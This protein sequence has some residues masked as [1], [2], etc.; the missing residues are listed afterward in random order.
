MRVS[1]GFHDQQADF[2]VPDD[3]LALAWKSPA[4]VESVQVAGRI[5]QA[6]REPVGCPPLDQSVVPGDQVVIALGRDVP[7]VSEV[8]RVVRAMLRSSGVETE[9]ITI[10]AEP[11]SPASL[12][13]QIPEGIVLVRHDPE[14]RTNLAYLASTT[15]G[16][17]VYLNR[18]L[19]DADFVMA[20][21]SLAY[22]PLRGQRCPSDVI[23]PG[24]SDTETRL[25]CRVSAKA[26]GSDR[27]TTREV[28][29]E[30]NEVNWLLGCHF[31][32]GVVPASEGLLDIAAG[33]H[34]EV[35]EFGQRSVAEFW[36]VPREARA[37]LVIVGVG[38]PGS[39][40]TIETVAQGLATA[41][42]LVE[43]GGK[44]VVLSR[45]RGPL[46]PAMQRLVGID[47][48]R[49]ALTRLEGCKNEP[50]HAAAVQVAKAIDWADVY[51]HG[52]LGAETAEDLAMIP[53]DR[54]NEARG[55]VSRSRSCLVVTHADQVR[56]VARKDE[57]D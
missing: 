33:E 48:P 39:E 44:I 49:A 19:T 11:G 10:L 34:A 36:T 55:L 17:R 2:E 16:R 56:V 26:P 9:A 29:A 38:S 14:D 18:L 57:I 45:A 53:L 31:V 35:F 27:R 54:P 37:E 50:D 25:L 15:Q 41:R 21:G 24:L 6:L 23:F 30:M 20:V 46:G 42:K 1:V 51:L 32:L 7:E 40:S 47:N 5:A 13:S 4:G 8:L 12:E 43:R 52:E 28:L 3:R 22:D